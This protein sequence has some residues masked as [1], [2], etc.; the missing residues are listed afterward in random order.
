MKKEIMKR[1]LLFLFMLCFFMCNVH[2]YDIEG[3]L[4]S[5]YEQAA[6]AIE[7]EDFR[8]ADLCLSRYMGLLATEETDRKY[9]SL[10]PLFDKYEQLEMF[11][12]INGNFDNDFINWYLFAG[13]AMWGGEE[14][15]NTDDGALMATFNDNEKLLVS[16][17][18]YPYL[19]KAGIVGTETKGEVVILALMKKPFL[20]VGKITGGSHPFNSAQEIPFDVKTSVQ[21]VWPP[22]FYDIDKDGKDEVFIRYNKAWATGFSQVLD[23]YKSKDNKLVFWERFEGFAEGIAKREGD[24]IIRAEGFSVSDKDSLPQEKTR[25]EAFEYIDGKWVLTSEDEKPHILMQEDWGQYY[26]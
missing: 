20:V 13:H 9:A 18:G 17:F 8:Q 24:K 10:Y 6:D 11:S 4:N 7:K 26:G 14:T 3:A 15:I 12:V 2:A 23:I 5:L 16:V 22:D 1:R 21:Y 25:F 19:E